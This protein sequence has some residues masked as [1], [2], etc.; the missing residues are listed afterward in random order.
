MRLLSAA[1]AADS[2]PKKKEKK[3]AFLLFDDVWMTRADII[4]LVDSLVVVIFGVKQHQGQ[5]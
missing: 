2:R 3:K 5:Q 1:P 4:R